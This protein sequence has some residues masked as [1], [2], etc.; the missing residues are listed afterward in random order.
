MKNSNY[1]I[2]GVMN[3]TPDS[4]SD[5][6]QNNSLNDVKTNFENLIQEGA[7]IIDIGAHS[8]APFNK[9]IGR[10][11]EWN[12]IRPFLEY[13]KDNSQFLFS[14]DTYRTEVFR[15]FQDQ[16]RTPTIF[17]DVSGSLD[18][19]LLEVLKQFPNSPYVFCHNRVGNREQTIDHMK[20]VFK[21]SNEEFLNDLINYFQSALEWFDK[22][23]IKNP[24]ILDPTFGF[25]KT[26]EQNMFLL[27]SLEK[28]IMKFSGQHRWLIGISRKSFLRKKMSEVNG[29]KQ[30]ENS[31][32]L[33][34]Y[35]L[36]NFST[37]NQKFIFRVH[38]PSISIGL[39]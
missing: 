29:D 28:V 18:N 7:D 33:H 10:N 19:E 9:K 12:R 15:M 13:F 30:F 23:N 3:L 6:D 32:Y 38:S 8:T 20:Y 16:I 17:N 22:N 11:E 25:S 1:T 36:N 24:L 5:G 2:M 26:Y 14:L 35:L 31:E 21:G 37:L 4:F 34:R 39:N 27:N